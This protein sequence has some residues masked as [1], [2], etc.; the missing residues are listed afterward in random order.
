MDLEQY[1]SYRLIYT[2]VQGVKCSTGNELGLMANRRVAV[3]PN[4]VKKNA[5]LCFV[6][7]CESMTDTDHIDYM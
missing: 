2:N 7:Y 1:R 4:V 6:L 5:L 3:F